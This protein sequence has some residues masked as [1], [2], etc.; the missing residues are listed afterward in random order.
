MA[1]TS[2]VRR[3]W[4]I[5][6]EGRASCSIGVLAGTTQ[7]GLGIRMAGFTVR[8]IYIIPLREGEASNCRAL[9]S[10]T[11]CLLQEKHE[12]W[13]CEG[14]S[15]WQGLRYYRLHQEELQ[16][17]LT[18]GETHARFTALQYASICSTVIGAVAAGSRG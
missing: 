7:P 1:P 6:Q 18:A 9:N 15:L 11:L 2:V 4:S 12:Y 5:Q 17:R 3:V 10:L 8:S 14:A 13:V 16:S